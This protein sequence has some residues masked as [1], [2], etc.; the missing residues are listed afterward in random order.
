MQYKSFSC[1][2]IN[3]LERVTQSWLIKQKWWKNLFSTYNASLFEVEVG[4]MI[5]LDETLAAVEKG[6]KIVKKCRKYPPPSD[7]TKVEN[8]FLN[9]E[10]KIDHI[11]LSFN[12]WK[13]PQV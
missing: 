4:T 13:D 3:E 8:W 9:Y 2:K 10:S 1:I 7:V 11:A 6:C 5:G 12:L